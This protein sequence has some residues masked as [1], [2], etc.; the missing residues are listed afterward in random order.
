MVDTRTY[1]LSGFKNPTNVQVRIQGILR[2]AAHLGPKDLLNPTYP[3]TA[4][5][6]EITWKVIACTRGPSRLN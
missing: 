5:G 2:L 6:K 3:Y 1:C 4:L